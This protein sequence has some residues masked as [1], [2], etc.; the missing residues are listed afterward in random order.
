M[1]KNIL[2]N[3]SSIDLFELLWLL[4]KDDFN[5]NTFY[6]KN[7]VVVPPST[8]DASTQTGDD[9]NVD[10]AIVPDVPVV[11]EYDVLFDFSLC[12]GCDDDDDDVDEEHEHEHEEPSKMVL[13]S[14]CKRSGRCVIDN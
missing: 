6:K 1:G 7:I 11:P 12:P 10:D 3:T 8:C 9:D 2:T 13:R 5:Q 4:R 14:D